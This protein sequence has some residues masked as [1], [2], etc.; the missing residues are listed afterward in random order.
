MAEE[1][2]LNG[3]KAVPPRED[4]GALVGS[5][6]RAEENPKTARV[7]EAVES[8]D[9]IELS[10]EAQKKIADLQR[11]DQEVR[12]HEAAHLAAGGSLVRGGATYGYQRGPDGKQ[13][14]VS[15]EVSLDTSPVPNNPAATLQ[16]AQQIKAAAT[17]PANPSPQDRK[18]AAAAG[19]MALKAAAELAQKGQNRFERPGAN[20]DVVA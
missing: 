15:G 1:F 12:A 18:V 5:D 3:V 2:A 10:P 9:S 14:A 7:G 6:A 16:K 11:R 13:Y 17:A 19:A 8:R 4:K 20:V